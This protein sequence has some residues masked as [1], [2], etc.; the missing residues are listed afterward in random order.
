MA[1]LQPTRVELDPDARE[2]VITWTSGETTRHDYT[3]LRKFCPC[4]NCT[5]ERQKALQ[6]K[7]L[8]IISSPNP[9]SLEPRIAEVEPVG[10][11]A[12]KF[13]WDD[14]HSAGIYTYD[15][16]RLHRKG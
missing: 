1:I 16:L 3:S 2:L 7:G 10:R 9:P 11:Y 5:T 4:A 14:G 6:H 15:F 12:L 13:D 8:R